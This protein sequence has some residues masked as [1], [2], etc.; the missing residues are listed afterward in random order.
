[1]MS[2]WSSSGVGGAGWSSNFR[3]GFLS[4]NGASTASPQ[5]WHIKARLSKLAASGLATCTR[6]CRTRASCR[7]TISGGLA[8][9]SMPLCSQY[10]HRSRP[11]DAPSSAVAGGA[12]APPS[13]EALRGAGAGASTDGAP[14]NKRWRAR[15]ETP[16]SKKGFSE[17]EP[18]RSLLS[19][20]PANMGT[21]TFSYTPATDGGGLA[22]VRLEVSLLLPMGVAPVS[23]G[24]PLAVESREEFG[25]CTPNSEAP[26]SPKGSSEGTTVV[27]LADSCDNGHDVEA[28]SFEGN[29]GWASSS[30]SPSSWRGLRLVLGSGSAVAPGGRRRWWSL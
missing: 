21:Y 9:T 18:G 1:M 11:C 17:G 2:S 12:E 20:A 10:A 14:G 8:C 28:W 22:E 5:A 13:T 15:K 27:A 6:E 26:R 30:P 23:R 16:R 7:Q 4:L 3:N 24:A 25:R 29:S 19:S